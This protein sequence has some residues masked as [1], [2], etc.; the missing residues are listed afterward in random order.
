VHQLQDLA[1]PQSG[2]LLRI[3]FLWFRE[4]PAHP[5]N[6]ASA[7]KEWDVDMK[8]ATPA[9]R[10]RRSLWVRAT[11]ADKMFVMLDLPQVIIYFGISG[12]RLY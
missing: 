10:L 8:S 3:L 4:A 7:R 1:A 6:V 12:A 9:I 5:W 11:G 2:G